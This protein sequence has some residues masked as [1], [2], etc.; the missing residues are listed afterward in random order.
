MGYRETT[1]YLGG[2]EGQPGNPYAL[3]HGAQFAPLV[4]R[5]IGTAFR[6][7]KYV[8]DNLEVIKYVAFNMEAIVQVA[9]QFQIN[10][11]QILASAEAATNAANLAAT[12]AANMA[13]AAQ[14]AAT[15]AQLNVWINAWMSSLPVWSGT[16][17]LPVNTG[18]WFMNNGK[19]EQA[20]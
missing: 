6:T 11:P 17:P 7:V 3:N 2:C 4:D 13:A 10:N 9:Q 20:Q 18:G 15:Q 8:A 14:S 1:N 19:P 5:L 16:G 12:N